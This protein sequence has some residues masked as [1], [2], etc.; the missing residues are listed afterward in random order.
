MLE[1]QLAN[2]LFNFGQNPR[3]EVVF[4]L[5]FNRDFCRRVWC[6]TQKYFPFRVS[7]WVVC[8][9]LCL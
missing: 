4:L 2:K 5:E 1:P 8:V 9:R 6:I 3:S 7:V